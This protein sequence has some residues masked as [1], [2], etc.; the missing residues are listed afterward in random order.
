MTTPI[1]VATFGEQ[2]RH[3]RQRARMTQDELGLAVGLSWLLIVIR[4]DS[5]GQAAR[6]YSW[7]KPLS[8]GTLMILPAPCTG[9]PHGIP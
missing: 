7:C 4:T 6:R 1:P 3:L 5:A 9:G 2:L 8:T